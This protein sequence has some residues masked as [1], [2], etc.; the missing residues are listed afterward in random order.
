MTESP[1]SRGSAQLVA[2]G[3]KELISDAS[4]LGLVW[5]LKFATVTTIVG[6]A[7]I[8][9]R[10][11]GDPSFAAGVPAVLLVPAPVVGERVV[12][13]FVPPSGNYVIANSTRSV[14][15]GDCDNGEANATVSETSGVYV[16]YPTAVTNSI[17][18]IGSA[19]ESA[20]EV[21]YSVTVFVDNAATGGD[22][23]VNIGGIDFRTHRTRGT[24]VVNA[25]FSTT[26]MVK[27]GGLAAGPY[28]VIP[29]WART[30]GVGT[31]RAQSGDDWVSLC[32]R[33]ITPP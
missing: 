31:I 18:K 4:R 33:E 7:I 9:V 14:T 11:D 5:Q 8:N 6:G 20:L 15:P 17:T 28:T 26:G 1:L 32:V 13:L 12:V 21:H 25:R 10:L 2:A 24:N 29:R 23:A 3:V 30:G 27:A 16:N 22:F 19:A